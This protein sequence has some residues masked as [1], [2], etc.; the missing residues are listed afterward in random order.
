MNRTVKF[1]LIGAA[2]AY[3]I[4]ALR[5]S[6]DAVPGGPV[7]TLGFGALAGLIAAKVL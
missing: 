6:N 5:K 2:V 4:G 7:L 3:A 1:A